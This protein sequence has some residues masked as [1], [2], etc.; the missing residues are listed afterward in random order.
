MVQVTQFTT[1]LCMVLSLK[2]DPACEIHAIFVLL[3]ILVMDYCLDEALKSRFRL[4]FVELL[5]LIEV[6]LRVTQHSSN[7]HCV[8]CWWLS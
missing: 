3:D 1:H 4:L 6:C 8:L 7:S 2:Y 5:T